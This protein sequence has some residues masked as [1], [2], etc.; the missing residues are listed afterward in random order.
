MIEFFNKHLTGVPYADFLQSFV[1]VL[2]FL[3]FCL[4]V[5]IV[6]RKPKNYYKDINNLPI[7]ENET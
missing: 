7:E 1:L 4:T 2:F 3:V 5:F 6:Y